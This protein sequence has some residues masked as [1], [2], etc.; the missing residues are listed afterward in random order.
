MEERSKRPAS[1]HDA[2]DESATVKDWLAEIQQ[3]LSQARGPVL[4]FAQ[5]L[6][7]QEAEELRHRVEADDPAADQNKEL[8]PIIAPLIIGA[9]SRQAAIA[10]ARQGAAFILKSGAAGAAG[11]AGYDLYKSI[12]NRS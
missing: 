5:E 3:T 10:G 12:R 1:A 6:T 9:I 4:V 7:D 8:I 2:S 11:G